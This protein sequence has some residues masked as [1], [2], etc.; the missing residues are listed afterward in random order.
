MYPGQIF[1]SYVL[2]YGLLLSANEWAKCFNV[3]ED[4]MTTIKLL[5]WNVKGISNKTKRSKIIS[6]LKSRERDVQMLQ[7]THLKNA[8]M[9]RSGFFS[10]WYRA[11]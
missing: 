4:T 6:H 8:E 1:V 10:S 5:S 2:I 7:E 11:L 9:G 3:E